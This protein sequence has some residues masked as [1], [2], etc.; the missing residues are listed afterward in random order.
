MLYAIKLFIPLNLL[1]FSGEFITHVNGSGWLHQVIRFLSSWKSQT[2]KQSWLKGTSNIAPKIQTFTKNEI[3]TLPWSI[4]SH[5]VELLHLFVVYQWQKLLHQIS[6]ST[7]TFKTKAVQWYSK[8]SYSK[9]YS[10][11]KLLY[12]AVPLYVNRSQ[13]T[14]KC[15]ITKKCHT[16][17]SQECYW[18]LSPHFD[19]FWDLFLNSLTA[20]IQI[21]HGAHRWA[22]STSILSMVSTILSHV[23]GCSVVFPSSYRADQSEQNCPRYFY[24]NKGKIWSCSS[25]K[26]SY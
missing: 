18:M 5:S 14:S 7:R 17:L 20:S 19:I 3:D 6:Q 10:T 15:G 22:P 16:R 24:F 13:M 2:E 25:K 12:V 4:L 23:Q 8:S 1:F 11:A 26:V 9:F 21:H